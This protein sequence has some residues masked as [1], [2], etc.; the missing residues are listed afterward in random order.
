[1]KI[2]GIILL[3]IGLLAAVGA[4][5][6]ASHGHNT[7]FVGAFAFIVLGIFLISRANKKK[8]E[9][10]KKKKWEEGGKID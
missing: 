10:E 5:I 3:V 1:M 4:I 7:S 2:A 6:G 9:V 8:E